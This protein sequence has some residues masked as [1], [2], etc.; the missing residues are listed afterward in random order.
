[1]DSETRDLDESLEIE[2]MVQDKVSHTLFF[3]PGCYNAYL[4]WYQERAR[5]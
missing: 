1:M 5:N 2:E 3:N 4:S